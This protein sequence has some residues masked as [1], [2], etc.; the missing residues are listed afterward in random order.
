VEDCRKL[1]DESFNGRE[2]ESTA[3]AA[4]MAI[5]FTITEHFV[6]SDADMATEDDFRKRTD[7]YS[8]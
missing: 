3:R 5:A 1:K 6:E 4:V 2:P 7:L 8:L